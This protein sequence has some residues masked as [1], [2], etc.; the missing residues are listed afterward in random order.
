MSLDLAIRQA[1]PQEVPR[2]PVRAA[3]PDRVAG[4]APPAISPE[5]GPPNPRLRMDRDLGMVVIEFRDAAGKVATSLPS[6]RELQAY[7][8]SV[9]YGADLPMF[10]SPIRKPTI[11]FTPPKPSEQR[12]MPASFAPLAV[13]VQTNFAPEGLQRT[14]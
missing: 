7:R 2:Q 4:A 14:A 9:N 3:G 12:P 13:A 8:A 5:L 10:L 11:A 1:P 6:E